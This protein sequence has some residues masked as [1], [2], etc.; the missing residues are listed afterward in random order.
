[1]HFVLRNVEVVFDEPLGHVSESEVTLD[2]FF[3]ASSE[4]HRFVVLF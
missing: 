3:D 2:V 4:H 1:V